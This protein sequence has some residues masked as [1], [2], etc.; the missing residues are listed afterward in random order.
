MKAAKETDCYV[1]GMKDSSNST[2]WNEIC[3]TAD[4]IIC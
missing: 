2:V 3:E 1:Y 4:D